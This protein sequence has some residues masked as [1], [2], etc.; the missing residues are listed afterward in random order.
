MC[1]GN[2]CPAT[3]TT[4]SRITDV[5]AG[6]PELSTTQDVNWRFIANALTRY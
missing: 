5:W 1:L 6:K 3:R 2:V 4:R